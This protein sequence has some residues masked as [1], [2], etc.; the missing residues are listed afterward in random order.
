M[1]GKP[2]REV[3]T[4]AL[5]SAVLCRRLLSCKWLLDRDGLEVEVIFQVLE[6]RVREEDSGYSIRLLCSEP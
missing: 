6:A 5:H 2:N 4:L 1:V 3:L